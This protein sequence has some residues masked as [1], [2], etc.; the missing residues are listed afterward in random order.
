MEERKSAFSVRDLTKMALCLAFCLVL[1]FISFPLPMTPGLVT[2]LT[3]GL[4]ITA[5]VLSPKLAFITV[6]AYV[7]LGAIG[8]PVFP[9]GAGG[10][11]RLLGPTGGFYFGW[12]IVCCIESL[13]KG[14]E[15]SFKRY[16]LVSIVAGVP[17]TYVGGLISMMLVLHVNLWEGMAMAVL[18]FIPGD[19][20]KALIASF[21]AVRIN[22]ML[23]N[24]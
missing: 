24:R 11:G 3:I 19:I 15:P 10:L 6:A 9:G 18:P 22:R 14:K 5:F 7:F 8:L 17:L 2:A 16:A 23:A 4:T 12:P 20:F 1:S 21:I 13:L